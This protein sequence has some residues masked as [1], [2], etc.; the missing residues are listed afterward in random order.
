MRTWVP[1]RRD[2]SCSWSE[3][4]S[5]YSSRGRTW[6]TCDCVLAHAC[7]CKVRVCVLCACAVNFLWAGCR[8]QLPKVGSLHSH[9]GRHSPCFTARSFC[10]RLSTSLPCHT[11]TGAT[12][13]KASPPPP[14]CAWWGP[15]GC[16]VLPGLGDTFSDFDTLWA[17]MGCSFRFGMLPPLSQGCGGMLW[18]RGLGDGARTMDAPLSPREAGKAHAH[19]FPF[20][21]F[22]HSALLPHLSLNQDNCARVLLVRGANKEVKNFNSQTSFQVRT[23]LCTAAGAAESQRAQRLCCRLNVLQNASYL[24]VYSS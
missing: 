19:I 16:S 15:R 3:G 17:W 12:G 23:Q 20:F 11:C 9:I 7:V 6:L 21:S 1:G 13:V 14:T 10:V 8:I 2:G 18:L 24:M 5:C 22:F 4:V